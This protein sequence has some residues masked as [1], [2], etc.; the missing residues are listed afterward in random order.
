MSDTE[1]LQAELQTFGESLRSGIAYKCYNFKLEDLR[2][3]GS[4]WGAW[5]KSPGVYY[6]VEN[7]RIVY[8]G[9]ALLSTGL[10]ARVRVQIESFGDPKWNRVIKNKHVVVGVICLAASKW[11]MAAA[12]EVY[13]IDRFEMPE[14][15]KR[16]Q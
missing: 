9:R 16:I 3:E 12:L 1:R 7:G 15:N 4:D 14:F 6:F 8:I 10:G 2:S 5:E 11:Y 13:L